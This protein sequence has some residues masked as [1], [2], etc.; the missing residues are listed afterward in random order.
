MVSA[1]SAVSPTTVPTTQTVDQKKVNFKS[2]QPN[3]GPKEVRDFPD[4]TEYVYE[5][6]GSTGKKWGVGI[7]SAFVPG[8]GQAINGQWGKGF[9][10]LAGA[11]LPQIIGGVAGISGKAGTAILGGLVSVG[12]GI[13]SIVDAVKGAK[14][15]ETVIM[16]KA[17]QF[18]S[19]PAQQQPIN[20]QA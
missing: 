20:Y 3:Y 5:T 10:F 19:Q 13:W 7:A 18:Q 12:V 14:S 6:D 8:L 9:A 1:I 15:T 2:N 4:R 17:P 11:V 16:P